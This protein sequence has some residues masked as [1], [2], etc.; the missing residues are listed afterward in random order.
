MKRAIVIVFLVMC[1]R[2]QAAE[3]SADR[4]QSAIVAALTSAATEAVLV[5]GSL[6]FPTMPL[7]VDV[8]QLVVDKL[9][10][11]RSGHLDARVQCAPSRACLPFAVSGE[12]F[13][14]RFKAVLA[15]RHSN[16]QGSELRTAGAQIHTRPGTLK[17]GHR[18][19]FVRERDG[20]R[21][22]IQAVTL[23]NAAV[24]DNVR[25]RAIDGKHEIMRGR[26][27]AQHIVREES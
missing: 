7:R 26:L 4:V 12:V 6:R 9:T 16:P 15:T 2:A 21:M 8:A 22:H 1:A 14:Q 17:L 25:V 23:D 18:V 20:V 3:L 13:G 24:G 27:C 10:I 11:S 5:P 19:L